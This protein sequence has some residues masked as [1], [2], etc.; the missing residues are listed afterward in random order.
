MGER[1]YTLKEPD[2]AMFHAIFDM[3]KRGLNGGPVVVTLGREKRTNKQNA[4]LWATLTD[5]SKQ[6]EWLDCTGQYVKLD[7]EDWQHVFTA[8]LENQKT[9]PGIQ[10]GLVVLGVSTRSK[11]KAWFSDLFEMI[12]AFGA[13]R[14]VRWSDPALEAFDTNNCWCK[15]PFQLFN[16]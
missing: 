1:V 15:Q 16:C 3:M 4:R 11:S 10:G 12:H 9:V 5:V 8:A 13:E 2:R 6:V 14:G 7:R